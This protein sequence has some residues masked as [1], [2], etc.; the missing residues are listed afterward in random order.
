MGNPLDEVL[1]DVFPFEI[2]QN[3]SEVFVLLEM[4]AN[5]NGE[6]AVH[7]NYL[8]SACAKGQLELAQKL[9]QHGADP[10]T[11]DGF[12]GSALIVACAKG[13]LELAQKLLQHGADPNAIGG[14]YGSALMAAC[15][16][17]HVDIAWELI[18]HNA[19]VNAR[20]DLAI[21]LPRLKG[22]Y[23]G[24]LHGTALVAA[25][26]KGQLELVRKF[27]Q[28]GA[29]PNVTCGYYGSALIAACLKGQVQIV[30][31]LIKHKADVNTR[32]DLGIVNRHGDMNT[33]Y[34]GRKYGTALQTAC[35]AWGNSS[36][37]D[38]AM[39]V[40]QLLEAGANPNI[41]IHGS[42]GTPLIAACSM[43]RPETVKML[44]LHKAYVNIKLDTEAALGY[45]GYDDSKNPF[46]GRVTQTALQTACAGGNI[47][48]VKQLLA[49]GANIW[50]TGG[51][52]GSAIYAAYHMERSQILNALFEH[53]TTSLKLPNEALKELFK[54][55]TA[56]SNVNIEVVGALFS[57][58]APLIKVNKEIIEALFIHYA[59]H[60]HG[61]LIHSKTPK[62]IAEVLDPYRF[63]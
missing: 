51:Y 14:Y 52:Y 17:R 12:D 27:L 33:G 62:T 54:H 16:Q 63:R 8:L 26:D 55:A 4:G 59:N 24:R 19:D 6:H 1:R 30:Q 56:S 44:L 35:A 2:G 50:A 57:H 11:T 38:Y 61:K 9:L 43:E 32:V 48:I 23:Y 46:R 10:N 20:V 7:G 40:E 36:D 34:V 3:L 60:Q 22:E 39:I 21:G 18:K 45:D 13:H 58:T 47:D 49:K 37:A 15:S 5:P 25:C 31:E 53:A 41:M 28:L 42:F 29:N